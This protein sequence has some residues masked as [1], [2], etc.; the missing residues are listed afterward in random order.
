[1]RIKYFLIPIAVTIALCGCAAQ[2][3]LKDRESAVGEVR[4]MALFDLGCDSATLQLT[5]LN[6][7]CHFG[8]CEPTEIGAK[9][10]GKQARYTLVNAGIGT[11]WVANTISEQQK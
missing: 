5:V 10:C 11:K 1:M 4:K 8:E 2:L 3:T 6:E 9:G 7:V